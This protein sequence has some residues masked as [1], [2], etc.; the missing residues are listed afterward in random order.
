MLSIF[1]KGLSTNQTF[2]N[3]STHESPNSE[4]VSLI[5]PRP[6]TKP[7]RAGDSQ[8]GEATSHLEVK[9]AKVS[10]ILRSIQFNPWVG[11]MTAGADSANSKKKQAKEGE[12]SLQE[13]VH[14]IYSSIMLMIW[15]SFFSTGSRVYQKTIVLWLEPLTS[16]EC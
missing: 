13:N 15:F 3:S 16:E 11:R 9:T 1:W 8:N 2:V 7:F 5:L 6:L 12:I 10:L 4:Y 14:L